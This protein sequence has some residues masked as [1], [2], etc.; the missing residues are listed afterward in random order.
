LLSRDFGKRLPSIVE[1]QETADAAND[2]TGDKSDKG[3]KN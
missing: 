3:A 2:K 1:A